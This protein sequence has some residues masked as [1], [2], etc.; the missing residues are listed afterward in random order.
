[1]HH[2]LPSKEVPRYL[3]A[4][5]G[6]ITATDFISSSTVLVSGSDI[7]GGIGA[8]PGEFIGV[9]TAYAVAAMIEIPFIERLARRWHY[10]TLML[11][12]LALF[13]LSALVATFCERPLS[14]QIVRFVQGIGG[15]GLFT[16]SRVYLQLAVPAADRPAHLKGYIISLL[17]SVAPASWMATSLVYH[18]AWQSVFLLQAIIGAFALVLTAVF[19]KAERHTPRTLGEVDWVMVLGFALGSALLLHVLEDLQIEL[20][21]TPRVLTLG[22]AFGALGVAGWRL[23]RHEDPLMNTRIVQGRRYLYGLGFYCIYY[24]VNGATSF[25]FPKLFEAGFGYPLETVGT[26]LSYSACVTVVLLPIYFHLARHMGD[27]RRVIA[28]SFA[29]SAVAMFW[30]SSIGTVETPAV[31]LLGA[32]TLKGI[33]P[34]LG[35]IQIAGLTYREVPHEDFAHAY[36]LKNIGRQLSNLA[37][38]SIASQLWQFWSAQCRTDLVAAIPPATH[39]PVAVLSRMVDQQVVVLVGNH[40]LQMLALFCVIAIPLVLA[41]KTLR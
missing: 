26:L 21:D 18:G 37:S 2:P 28:I 14:L 40:L 22:L 38:A 15:G 3:G 31:M 36:A 24:L 20:L 6:L 12:G 33:F 9:F 10:R 32:L 30:L 41:Q 19:I 16:M 35:V 25:I 34:I 7:Q 5:L 27:R 11:A 1:M 8:S 23:W 29:L 39:I 4:I 17:G 13:I